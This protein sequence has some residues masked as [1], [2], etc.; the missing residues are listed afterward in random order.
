MVPTQCEHLGTLKTT[1]SSL[2]VALTKFNIVLQLE[3]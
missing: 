1:F 3:H 2:V